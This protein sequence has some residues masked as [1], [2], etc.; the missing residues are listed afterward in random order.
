MI[1]EEAPPQLPAGTRGDVGARCPIPPRPARLAAVLLS[2]KIAAGAA[3]S[4]RA[5]SPA[6]LAGD[7]ELDLADVAY[8]PRHH[9]R[10]PASTARSRSATSREQLLAG[11]RRAGR[12]RTTPPAALRPPSAGAG[13]PG[14]SLHR[15]GLPSGP[16]W[17]RSC[18]RAYPAF[19]EALRRGLRGAR[20]RTSTGRCARCS[21]ADPAR[22]GG[23]A[24]PHQLRPAGP[25]R[26]RGRAV[27]AAR[28]LVG[29]EPDLLAGHSVGEIA[30]AHVAGVLSLADA[31]Q[32][33]R[34]RGQL[35]Q[36][37]PAG[38][39]MVAVEATESRGRCA[40]DRR[41][42][43]GAVSLAAINGPPRW[44]LR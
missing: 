5:A 2:A 43:A 32:A 37:L 39:A 11:L 17:A 28:V 22:Q 30:A 13:P 25:L 23:A 19:A 29:V 18:T 21:S 16:G 12:G 1:L 42:C 24:G 6:H 26:D 35:M 31:A 9:P 15:P 4:R 34:A 8:S 3:A 10:R 20:R 27:P 38:G 44:C 41:Q 33:G 7:P 40:A 14:L 36:A